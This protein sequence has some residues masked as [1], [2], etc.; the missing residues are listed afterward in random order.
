MNIL[1]SEPKIINSLLVRVLFQIYGSSRRTKCE[2]MAL[3]LS[4]CL[5]Y[6][7]SKGLKIPPG[8]KNS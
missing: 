2:Q 6:N 8:V 1:E 4:P 5:L 7:H 3:I